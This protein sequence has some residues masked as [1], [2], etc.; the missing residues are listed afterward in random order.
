MTGK[1]TNEQR[2]VHVNNGDIHFIETTW[3]TKYH[4][5]LNFHRISATG[6]LT[7]DEINMTINTQAE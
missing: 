4:Q 7:F 2:Q 5:T 3:K 1:Q 6:T